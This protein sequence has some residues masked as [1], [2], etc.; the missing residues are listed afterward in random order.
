MQNFWPRGY[1]STQPT[2]LEPGD[3]VQ[4]TVATDLHEI[5]AKRLAH[6]EEVVRNHHLTKAVG[7]AVSVVIHMAQDIRQDSDDKHAEV[8]GRFDLVMELMRPAT[9]AESFQWNLPI[10]N[11]FFTGR[12]DL[13][14]GL[15]G[16]LRRHG[17]VALSGLP[18]VGKTDAA[19]EYA[20]ENREKYQYIFYVRA[21]TPETLMA[22]FAALARPLNLP[23]KNEQ[24]QKLVVDAV[25][26]WLESRTEVDWLLIFDN[27]DDPEIVRSLLPSN[28]RGHVLLTTRLSAVGRV[29][30][31]VELNTLGTDESAYFLLSRA[32]LLVEGETLDSAEPDDAEAARAIA[33]E[34]D[35]L[36]L[37]LEQA[38]AFIQAQSRTPAE[39][40][41]LYREEGAELRAEGDPAGADG[42]A[43]VSAT[44]SLALK[45]VADVNP[46]AAD[47]L[48]L[49][50]FLSPDAIPE[51]ILLEGAPD[52]GDEL[53]KVNTALARTRVVGEAIRYSLLR[54]DS[55]ARLLS[56]HRVVQMVLRDGIS[57]DAQRLWAERAVRAVN[58][59]IP[60]EKFTNRAAY[61]RLLP[62][63][64]SC[65]ELIGN[66]EMEF[67]EAGSLLDKAGWYL[68]ERGLYGEAE[69]LISRALR[70]R[71][72]ALGLD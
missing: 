42:H 39:Y 22:D 35:G 66:Y 72:A 1:R 28:K 11:P 64:M 56:I 25:K 40:L 44:F 16:L 51:E 12:G 61:E 50:A 45:K 6:S 2:S 63:A 47:L 21:E 14:G 57:P 53:S 65:Y 67:A 38:G 55:K 33:R 20:H 8:I 15:Y 59:T 29:A 41:S 27:A 62:Q 46:A 69:P 5:I 26:H 49:C 43:P 13:L 30:H 4:Q 54:R 52:L 9:V 71:E 70:I 36:P 10:R 58:R 23:V 3:T 17:R 19:V 31:P 24:D 32:R 7:D 60:N 48:R 18:G 34:L 68:K 37:A